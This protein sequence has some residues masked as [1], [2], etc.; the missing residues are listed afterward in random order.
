M[1]HRS[2]SSDAATRTGEV[3]TTKIDDMCPDVERVPETK[4][5]QEIREEK[6]FAEEVKDCPSKCSQCAEISVDENIALT[7]RNTAKERES[8]APPSS[9]AIQPACPTPSLR[10]P[11]SQQFMEVGPIADVVKQPRPSNHHQLGY[12]LS[13]LTKVG[14]QNRRQCS[15][16]EFVVQ[17]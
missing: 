2:E 16:E 4:F 5:K 7:D 9:P 13:L 15:L 12:I 6:P 8:Q 3:T 14:D 10:C 11:V 17:I 1:Y